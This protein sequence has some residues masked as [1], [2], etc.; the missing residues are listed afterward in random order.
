[1]A[2]VLEPGQT[3]PKKEQWDMGLHCL[4]RPILPNTLNFYVGFIFCNVTKEG[5]TGVGRKT[6]FTRRAN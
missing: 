3:A 5:R 4:L 2:R 6:D 1:M